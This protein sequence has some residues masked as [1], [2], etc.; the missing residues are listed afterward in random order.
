MHQNIR[1]FLIKEASRNWHD[2]SE[3]GIFANETQLQKSNQGINIR[4][5][6]VYLFIRSCKKMIDKNTEHWIR[7]RID[8]NVQTLS[9]LDDDDKLHEKQKIS[10]TLIEIA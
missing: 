4:T 5:A 1:N 10:K 6:S 3:Q 8:D 7:K 2:I 9:S